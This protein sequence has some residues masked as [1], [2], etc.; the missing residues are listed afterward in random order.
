[1]RHACDT[2]P[3]TG[4]VSVVLSARFIRC[5]MSSTGLPPVGDGSG[6]VLTERALQ[7]LLITNDSLESCLARQRP[8]GMSPA[9]F[10]QFALSL[11]QALDNDGISQRDVRLQGSAAHFFAGHHKKMPW[12]RDDLVETFRKLRGRV[13]QPFEIDG[14]EA[15]LEVVWPPD[16][17]RP[18]RRPFDALHRLGLDR[19]P[20]DYDVQLAS[21]EVV[22]RATKALVDLGV[23]TD[24]P[25]VFSESYAFVR[26]DLVEATCPNLYLWMLEQSDITQRNVTVAAFP[27]CGP[28]DTGSI[29][30]SH[31][32]DSDWIL[33][34]PGIPS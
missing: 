27:A 3:L 25:F 18:V 32:R 2:S 20:S 7:F 34:I 24:S 30:S 17:P 22:Q 29:L 26:K 28:P 9:L 13:P 1:M 10:E 31:F 6:Y 33:D 5:G 8:L 19:E 23:S 21:D 15:Q 4:D 16:E 12:S 14:L 11:F